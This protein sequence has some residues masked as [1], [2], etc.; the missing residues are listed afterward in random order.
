MLL[1]RGNRREDDT[2]GR[3]THLLSILLDVGF[4]DSRESK[5]PQHTVGYTLE[6]LRVNSFY[7]ELN[8]TLYF[9]V[10]S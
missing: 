10:S 6:D 7:A 9:L 4:A 1:F 2:R 8:Y 3:K 5:K